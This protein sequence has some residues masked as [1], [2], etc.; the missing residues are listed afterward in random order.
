MFY[1]NIEGSITILT[2][3]RINNEVLTRRNL[4][5]S[6]KEWNGPKESHESQSYRYITPVQSYMWVIFS[7]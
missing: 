5:V 7:N 6:G 2:T 3:E 4:V 1:M